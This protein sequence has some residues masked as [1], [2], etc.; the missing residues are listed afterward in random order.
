MPNVRTIS[1]VNAEGTV[2]RMGGAARAPQAEISAAPGDTLRLRL[3]THHNETYAAGFEVP[4]AP[5]AAPSASP[6]PDTP[7]AN[8]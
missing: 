6:W 1:V 8:A 5:E 7:R 4:A 2:I 3:T